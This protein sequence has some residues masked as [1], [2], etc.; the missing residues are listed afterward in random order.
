MTVPSGQLSDRLEADCTH[1][2]QK[3]TEVFCVYVIAPL[4]PIAHLR[5]GRAQVVMLEQF[6]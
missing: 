4:L 1:G 3:T 2:A 6:V 5:I